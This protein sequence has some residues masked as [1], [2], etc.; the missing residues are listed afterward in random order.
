MD[1]SRAH[2]PVPQARPSNGSDSPEGGMSPPG[3]LL[4]R[5]RPG[6]ESR[7]LVVDLSAPDGFGPRADLSR[8]SGDR[9]PPASN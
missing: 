7:R 2:V 4:H 5:Y 8:W 9:H 3:N 6:A 1:G